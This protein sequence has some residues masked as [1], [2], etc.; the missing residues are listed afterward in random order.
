MASSKISAPKPVQLSDVSKSQPIN[1]TIAD[2]N[3]LLLGETGVGKTTF[4]NSFVNHLAYNT[5][6]EALKGD[7]IVIIPAAFSITDPETYDSKVI[8]IGP[9]DTNENNVENGESKTQGCK[10]YVFPLGNRKLRLIDAPGIGDTRGVEQ[11]A[12]N[13]EHILAYISQY[14][15]LDGI[16]ILL[17]PNEQRMNVLFRF[18]IKELLTHL[19]ISAKDNIMFVFT[20]GRSSFYVPG[21]TA[22]LLKTLLKELYDR[23]GVDV[24]FTKDNTFSFDNESFR[25]LAIHKNGVEFSRDQ[26]Q[27]FSKSWDVSVKE[28][29]NL[30][31]RIVR[32][33]PH[34]VRDTLSLNEAQ[35]LIKKLHRPIPE[36]IRLIQENIQLAKKYKLEQLNDATKTTAS[37]T[38]NSLSNN[39]ISVPQ[40]SAEFINLPYPRTVCTTESCTRVIIVEGVQK[41][42][43]SS[44]CHEHCYLENVQPELI[45][46]P[47]LKACAAMD[48]IL[49]K[50]QYLI[51][52]T[53]FHL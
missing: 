5:L 24:P 50:C 49:G 37:T 3:I 2:L 22:P 23:T 17:K 19:H 34:I 45:N 39:H 46:N 43:Y 33:T 44:H 9:P 47:A 18:C 48:Q 42:D 20:F 28:Y 40:Y 26:I 38:T 53:G 12:K 8:T 10:S 41:V 35:Q 1:E 25:F 36:V 30:V 6:D 13:F 21:H 31:E 27:D 14:K 51:K 32:C 52:L 29:G 16:C 15:H 7:M 11:D 4:I